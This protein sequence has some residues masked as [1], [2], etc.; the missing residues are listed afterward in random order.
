MPEVHMS[1]M[2]MHMMQPWNVQGPGQYR[3][4]A[5]R[6]TNDEADEI[7]IRPSHVVCSFKTC[8]SRSAS[9]GVSRISASRMK[10]FLESSWRA[11]FNNASHNSGSPRNVSVPL[12]SH[13]SRLCSSVRK[14]DINSVWKP[15]GSS[16]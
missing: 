16:T 15:A 9:P 11:T 2:S 1:V 3:N 12:I 14:S 6:K 13:R 8:S 5:Q 7:E 4:Q 10:H